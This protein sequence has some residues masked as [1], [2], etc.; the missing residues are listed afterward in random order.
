M[1]E[2]A[3]E[4]MTSFEKMYEAYRRAASCKRSKKE[5]IDFELDLSNNLWGIISRMENKT[6]RISGYHRFMIY[7]P[8]EREIQ[9]L[10]FRDRVVQHCLCDNILR[11]YFEKRLIYD[12]A[13]CR[14][15]KGTHFAMNRLNV[16]LR[17]H[18][19][20]HGTKGYILKYD[21][22]HYFD[23]IDHEILKRKLN[24]I[25]DRNV[26]GLLYHIINSYAKETNPITGEEKGLPMGNQTSQWFA[27]YYLDTLDR[28]IKEKMRIKHFIR[29][30][31]DGIIIHESKEYLRHVLKEMEQEAKELKVEFNEKTQIFPICE[32]VDFLGFRF[33][34]TDSGKVI[35]RLRT[36]NKKRWKRRLKKYQKDYCAGE[37]TCEEIKRS[38]VSYRGHLSHGH[39]YRLRNKVMSS[40]VLTKA[41][42][43]S[44]RENLSENY[45]EEKS[46]LVR[47]DSHDN[48]CRET[49]SSKKQGGF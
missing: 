12:N 31:D 6:Y 9:A 45:Q 38:I 21:I 41:K 37:K 39:T 49:F 8:K 4:A 46:L 1:E 40:F 14:E 36:S 26:L 28:V 15:G 22:R 13:A 47:A 20:K 25:P 3:F 30:M 35:R 34:L 2:N 23:S 43:K 29:Y 32:G 33:Y 11:P 44:E 48:S 10:S 24:G 16:F 19:K 17:E 42:R 27:L 7:D 5:V 18:Y